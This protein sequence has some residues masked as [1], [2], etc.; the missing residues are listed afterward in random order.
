MRNRLD[1]I[2]LYLAF[3]LVLSVGPIS[4]SCTPDS[5]P[6]G[7]SKCILGAPYYSQYQCGTCL[8]NEYIQQKS[9]GKYHCRDMANV[10]C[11]F[12]CMLEMNG[13][14]AG[15]VHDH[16]LCKSGSRVNQSP[17]PPHCLSQSGTDCTW[18]RRCLAVQYPCDGQAAYALDNGEHFC[19]L[20]LKK[21]EVF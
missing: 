18:Y 10:S 1:I 17:L 12:Q 3:V 15:P 6:A 13:R 21:L 5:G 9:S 4:F 2:G 7:G 8:T 20:Y 16:C 11:Y 19:S 14:E